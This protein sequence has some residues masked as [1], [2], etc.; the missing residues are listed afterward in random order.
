VPASAPARPAAR[1]PAAAG[2]PAATE[3]V[4]EVPAE[5]LGLAELAELARKV[6]ERKP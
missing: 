2:T 3:E 1:P 4:I 6:V 5:E